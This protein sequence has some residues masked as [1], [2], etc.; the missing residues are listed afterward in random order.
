MVYRLQMRL[1]SHIAV[2]VG[3][4]AA[5]ALIGPLASE[6]PYA[7]GAA[8]KKDQKRK[9]IVKFAFKFNDLDYPKQS[10]KSRTKWEYLYHET[11]NL[12]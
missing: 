12:P 11:L 4:L 10:L 5:A 9:Q 3:R 8:P 1:R 6:L 2:A 7:T